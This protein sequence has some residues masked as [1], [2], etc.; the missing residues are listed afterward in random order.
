MGNAQKFEEI[1]SMILD[2]GLD[3]T[4]LPKDQNLKIFEKYKSALPEHIYNIIVQVVVDLYE[5]GQKY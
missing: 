1:K 2:L 5:K 3:I 4:S